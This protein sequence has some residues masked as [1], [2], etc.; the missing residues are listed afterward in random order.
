MN[1]GAGPAHSDDS[2]HGEFLFPMDVFQPE[3]RCNQLL[4]SWLHTQGVGSK[5]LEA[6]RL[7]TAMQT[8]PR[9]TLRLPGLSGETL[10]LGLDWGWK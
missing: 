7:I 6:F 5:Q 3:A 10:M 1:G 9:L 4:L 2:M 8:S